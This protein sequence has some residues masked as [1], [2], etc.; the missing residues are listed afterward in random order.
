MKKWLV[1]FFFWATSTMAFDRTQ[2][3][4]SADNVTPL[5]NGQ[6]VPDVIM[7]DEKGKP[8]KLRKYVAKKPT[9]MVFY[10]GGWCPYCNA[11]LGQL[12]SIEPEL[13]KMGYQLMAISPEV[14]DK[15]NG[16]R[17][18]N[19]LNYELMSDFQLDV[20]KS[21][22]IAFR[23]DDKMMERYKN[24]IQFSKHKTETNGNLPAPSVFIV[25]TDGVIQFSYVNPSYNVRL[26]PELLLKAAETS[27]GGSYLPL[28]K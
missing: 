23:L 10:R 26:H 24:R 14:P 11:Q 15:I 2:I 9:I 16:M 28:K 21:F 7:W 17:E 19:D 5:L 18:K 3:A 1:L 12:N 13:L 22:G 6:S 20:A 4:D 25:D 8:V 27:L